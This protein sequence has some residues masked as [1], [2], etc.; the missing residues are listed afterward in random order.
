MIA[1]IE[2]HRGVFGVEPI[3]RVLPIAP[4]TFHRHAAIAR[5]P[6]LASDRARQ[7]V[8][9][10]EKIKAPTARAGGATV[11]ARSGTSFVATGTTSRVAPWSGSCIFTDYKGLCAA[12]EDDHP[13]SGAALPG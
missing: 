5:N 12:E 10:F 8:Q 7:D 11:P 4:A 2:K 9:D 13:R 1:F 6:E 3:C